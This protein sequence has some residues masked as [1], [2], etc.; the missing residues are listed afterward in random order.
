MAPATGSPALRETRMLERLGHGRTVVEIE[1]A[2][3][4]LGDRS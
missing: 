3:L 1:D 4:G 2:R